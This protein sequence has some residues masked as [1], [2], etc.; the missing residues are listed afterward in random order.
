MS[1]KA[2]AQKQ[3]RR[4]TSRPANSPPPLAVG[5]VELYTRTANLLGGLGASATTIR[6]PYD[7]HKALLNGLP[8]SALATLLGKFRVLSTNGKRLE[9]A[10]GVSL[11]TMQRKQGDTAKRL[12]TEQAGRAWQ[13]A[14]MLARATAVLGSQESAERWLEHPAIGLDRNV[15]IDLLATPAGA[16]MVDDYLTRLEYGVYT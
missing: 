7:V 5:D 8:G 9:R 2:T 12:S 6:D 10:I 14:E 4:A 3:A 1:T 16:K 11:R 13:F 15:P